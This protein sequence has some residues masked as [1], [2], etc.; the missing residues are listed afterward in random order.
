MTVSAMS[1]FHIELD[2]K[3]SYSCLLAQPQRKAQAP[4]VRLTICTM[5]SQQVEPVELFS[6]A[7]FVEFVLFS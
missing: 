3:S 5:N 7:I 4:S 1:Y 2:D 6:G